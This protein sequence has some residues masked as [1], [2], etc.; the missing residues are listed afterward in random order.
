MWSELDDNGSP[1]SADDEEDGDYIPDRSYAYASTE[2]SSDNLVRSSEEEEAEDS[3]VGLISLLAYK[4][5]KTKPIKWLHC[6]NKKYFFSENCFRKK[7][8]T[9]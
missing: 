9:I 4:K 2:Q 5:L 3:E 8:L 6:T 1:I 7:Q